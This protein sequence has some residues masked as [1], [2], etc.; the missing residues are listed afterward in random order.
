MCNV[1]QCLQDFEIPLLLRHPAS[2]IQGRRRLSGVTLLEV[3][4]QGSPCPGTEKHMLADT[5]VLSV[6]L[7]P[8]LRPL[9]R[10]LKI[11]PNRHGPV[12]NNRFQAEVPWLFVGGNSLA[13][14]DLMDPVARIGE[15]AGKRRRAPECKN[16]RPPAGA[17]VAVLVPQSLIPGEPATVFLRVQRA[18]IRVGGVYEKNH[19]GLRPA[20]MVE[21][22]L[23]SDFTASLSG[24]CEAI[25][26]VV[27]G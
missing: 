13:V 24:S 19:T 18:L 17:N 5:L 26:E 10:L 27:P 1:V 11:A 2:Q 25:V 3:D 12:V 21:I 14:C 22:K 23:S 8:E 7:V 4:E 16:D 15:E 9:E 20:E 6:G